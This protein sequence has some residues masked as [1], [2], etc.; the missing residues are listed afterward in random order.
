MMT[1]AIEFRY[2]NSCRNCRA[3]SASLVRKNRYFLTQEIELLL[4]GL[5]NSLQGKEMFP[6][7]NETW[8]ES[9][10]TFPM[11]S[12]TQTEESVSRTHVVWSKTSS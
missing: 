11:I 8:T 3:G 12:K 9:D 4:W 6:K 7:E 1:S 5:D 2:P 10:P